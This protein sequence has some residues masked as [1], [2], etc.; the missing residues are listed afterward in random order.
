MFMEKIKTILNNKLFV[1]LCLLPLLCFTCAILLLPFVPSVSITQLFEYIVYLSPRWLFLIFILPVLFFWKVLNGYKKII[2]FSCVLVV[3]SFQDMQL[4]FP[5]NDDNVKTI[6]ILSLNLGGGSKSKYLKSIMHNQDPDV[7]LFQEAKISSLKKLFVSPWQVECEGG[8][9]IASKFN[10]KL[11]GKYNR[12]IISGWG[13]FATFYE[14]YIKDK[15]LPVMNLHLETPRTILSDLMS[16]SINWRYIKTFRENKELQAS[17]ITAWA[18]SQTQFIM[19]GDFNMTTN[20]SLYEDYFSFY[21]NAIDEAGFGINYTK[22]TS[23]HGV[24]IDHVLTSRNIE[25]KS[26]KAMPSLGGDHRAILTSI[27]LR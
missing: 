5:S 21:Q 25:T 1:R 4:G 11:V 26:A 13:D 8:L 24:R 6:D 23:L 15:T 20:E 9:C 2:I 22:F 14:V 7:L 3:I 27:V 10:F 19:A 16:F 12:K 18:N 17:M